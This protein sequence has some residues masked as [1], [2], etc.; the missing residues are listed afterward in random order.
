M[1]VKPIPDG[2]HTVTPCL[3]VDGAA[4]ALD[5]Y[6]RAFGAE[7]VYRMAD[8][9]G[10]VLHAELK[11]GNSLVMLSDEFPK[12]DA[13]GPKSIGGTPVS[14]YVYVQD[15]DS[16]YSRAVEAGGKELRPVADQFYG[17]RT[18]ML[19]DPFGHVWSLA[20]HKEDVAKEEIRRRAESVMKEMCGE[21][22]K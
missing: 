11:I 16:V 18:G 5:F 6:K 12:M 8:P 13:R 10:R 20:T 7:E 3:V 15:V 19:K 9:S 21:T 22:A 14:L 4:T 17:D 2:Y 1:A